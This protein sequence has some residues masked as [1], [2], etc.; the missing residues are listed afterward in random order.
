MVFRVYFVASATAQVELKRWTSVS[1]WVEVGV[2]EPGKWRVALDTDAR[3]FG[4]AGQ[5]CGDTD[6]FT[7]PGGPATSVGP[8]P[9]APRPCAMRYGLPDIARR[10]VIVQRVLN[11]GFLSRMASYDAV[12]DIWP[13]LA[14]GCCRRRGPRRCTAA[15]WS[16]PRGRPRRCPRRCLRRCPRRCRRPR[17]RRRLRPRR[18][19]RRRPCRHRPPS[20]RPARRMRRRGHQAT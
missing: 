16:R 12:S 15:W 4:G 10:V 14:C 6:H 17:P 2:G 18:R 5:V 9:Q 8:Y 3:E 20:A 1:P 7:S 13:A 19:P 11:H